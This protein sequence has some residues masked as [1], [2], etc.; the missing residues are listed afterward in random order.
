MND[1]TRYRVTFVNQGKVYEMFAREVYQDSLYGFVTIEDLLFGER[2]QV[3]VDPGEER[4]RHE[5]KDVERFHVP[6]HAVIR[7]DEVAEI[8]SARIRDMVPGSN[9]AMFPGVL[10]PGADRSK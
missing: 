1:T 6:L 10:P 3:V 4:L 5:F 7:I 2:S 8:G 9:I